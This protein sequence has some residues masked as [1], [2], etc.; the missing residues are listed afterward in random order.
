[1]QKVYGVYMEEDKHRY[2]LMTTGATVDESFTPI[3][4]IQSLFHPKMQSV[5]SHFRKFGIR[6]I[7]SSDIH[8]EGLVADNICLCSDGRVLRSLI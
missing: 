2:S 5:L 3:G 8:Y 4:G 1:M 7:H 6:N